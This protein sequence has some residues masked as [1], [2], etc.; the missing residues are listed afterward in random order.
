MTCRVHRICGLSLLAALIVASAPP[1]LAEPAPAARAAT[2]PAGRLGWA[3]GAVCY[4]I[5]VRSFADSDSDG[6]GDLRGLTQRLDYLNDGNPNGGYDLGVDAIWLMP[7]FRSPS[8]HGYDVTDYE[9]VNPD[10][11]TEADFDRL[12]SEAHRR[13][14]KVI[15]D[16]PLNHTSAGHAWFREAAADS[17]SPRRDW[18]VWSDSDLAWS[19]PWNPSNVTWHKAGKAHY[20][21]LFRSSMPDLNFRTPAVRSEMERVA[22]LWLKRGVDGFR[23]D[24]TRHLIETGL[25]AGQSDTGETHA[26]LREFAAHVR[27]VK[28]EALLVGENWT[29]TQTIATYFGRADSVAR[30]DELP[31]NFNF[32]LAD[33]IVEGIRTG[34]A[35]PAASVLREMK[36][37]YPHGV[38]D[39]PFLT[40]H[41][42]QRVATQLGGSRERLRSAVVT[43]LT[44]PGAPV[45]YYGEEI[46]LRNGPGDDDRD[47]RTPMA[48]DGSP[49][50]GFTAG[51]PW[52][53]FA[54]DMEETNVAAQMK[55][56]ISLFGRYRGLIRVRRGYAAL[57]TGD[58]GLLT[59]V[60]RSTPVL[61]FTRTSGAERMLV[62]HNLGGAAATAGPYAIDVKSF[63]PVV[64][65]LGVGTPKATSRGV[66]ILLPPNSSGVWKLD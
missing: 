55:N 51:T 54:P 61:A 6:I 41:D 7:I 42:M 2:D 28:P 26:Y 58:L 24:A 18:Y 30:V 1:A 14:I 13:G 40:N 8:Y 10:Y 57:R 19:Q 43:L 9:H 53:P 25:G 59:S 29:D 62:V 47:K 65:D 63:T 21:G 15:L 16:L 44:L 35:R 20:Y 23:L 39:A 4:E 60:D 37:V 52:Q 17:K 12:L 11:G 45:L 5:F 48:W 56:P 33:A 32:P 27:R 38:I 31:C 64:L 49:G 46:G 34:D 50:G 36:R 22:D 3:D 66:S